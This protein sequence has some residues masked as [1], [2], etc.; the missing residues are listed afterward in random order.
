[1]NSTPETAGL[2]GPV[3]KPKRQISA[4]RRIISWVFIAFLIGI[5][6]FEWKAKSSQAN[7]VKGLEAA[8][9][10]V[11]EVGEI[12]L[13]Q[14]QSLK[15][16]NSSEE[17]D[18]SGI[19]LRIFHYRWIGVFKTYNLRL[20]VDEGEMVIAFDERAEG[21]YVSNLRALSR[22]NVEAHMRKVKMERKARH[23]ESQADPQEVVSGETS[24]T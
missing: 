16:G 23:E 15:V 11:G 21:R 8:M 24:E 5:V 9:E 17:I 7:S 6:V 12:P 19:S 1:M 10:E 18:E 2:P 3:S 13:Q 14:F 20:L 4:R 22:E